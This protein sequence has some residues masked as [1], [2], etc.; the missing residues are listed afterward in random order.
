MPS[1]FSALLVFQLE[2]C[3]YYYYYWTKLVICIAGIALWAVL[4]SFR[5]PVHL[6]SVIA[7]KLCLAEWNNWGIQE[8]ER[9]SAFPHSCVG[10]LKCGIWHWPFIPILPLRC[11]PLSVENPPG[12]IANIQPVFMECRLSEF[13]LKTFFCWR[14]PK[15]GE[16]HFQVIHQDPSPWKDCTTGNALALQ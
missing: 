3:Y 5:V 16:G 9:L 8:S 13:L 7:L 4:H 1:L 6:I 14:S 15:N 11:R 2:T 10:Y 12:C